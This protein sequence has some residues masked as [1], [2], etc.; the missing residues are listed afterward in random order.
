[1]CCLMKAKILLCIVCIY[2]GCQYITGRGKRSI[3]MRIQRDHFTLQNTETDRQV[4][5]KRQIM[6]VWT[7]RCIRGIQFSSCIWNRANCKVCTAWSKNHQNILED[8]R[9][10]KCDL[11]ETRTPPDTT[12]TVEWICKNH[13]EWCMAST[14]RIKHWQRMRLDML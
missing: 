13:K 4:N 3:R 11:L 12:S 14:L 6:T 1:M 10:D 8:S 5:T 2:W 9:E 7:E